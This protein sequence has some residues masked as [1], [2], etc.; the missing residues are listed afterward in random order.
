MILQI[1]VHGFANATYEVVEDRRLDTVFE[2]NVKGM[3]AFPT[4]N[5][6]IDGRITAE[7]GGTTSEFNN[8]TLSCKLK[9]SFSGL[10]DF[11]ALMP[12]AVSNTVT[13]IRLYTYDDQIALEYSDSV[14]LRY[15]PDNP[16]LIPGLEAQGEYIR[17]TATVQIIDNDSK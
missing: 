13:V 16:A 5:D 8:S 14:I 7:T 9:K 2:L 10:S 4:L 17:D 6:I 1:I 11:E 3:T 15:V 12:I